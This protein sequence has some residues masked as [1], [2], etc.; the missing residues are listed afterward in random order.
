MKAKVNDRIR[1]LVD[2]RS[3]FRDRII[4]R[5]TEG[6]I[7]E[8]YEQP[9]E[10]YAADFPVHDPTV[11]GDTTWENVIL[12]PDQFEVVSSYNGP[13]EASTAERRPEQA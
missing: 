12:Y 2:I 6:G 3:E 4:P 1:L 11:V 7:V 13:D 9:V 5:G 8:S 10:G